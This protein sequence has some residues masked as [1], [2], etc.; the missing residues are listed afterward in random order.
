MHLASLKQIAAYGGLAAFAV[1]LC[2]AIWRNG[3]INSFGLA[4][5]MMFG[6]FVALM[7]WLLTPRKAK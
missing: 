7:V 5:T 3:G 6:V 4:D 2:L 1:A